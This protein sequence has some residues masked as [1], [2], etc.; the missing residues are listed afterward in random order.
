LN[1]QQCYIA[2]NLISF[3]QDRLLPSSDV[4][5]E[6]NLRKLHFGVAAAAAAGHGTPDPHGTAAGMTATV[7]GSE[8]GTATGTGLG[9]DKGAAGGR[10]QPSCPAGQP[11]NTYLSYKRKLQALM[12]RDVTLAE[13][14]R[15]NLY[16]MRKEVELFKTSR[17]HSRPSALRDSI[18]ELRVLSPYSASGI[19]LI[20]ET[21]A[22]LRW[23]KWPEN[24]C[25]P[26]WRRSAL[27]FIFKAL[28]L[29][30]LVPL[31]FAPD[32]DVNGGSVS[33]DVCVQDC[34]VDVALILQDFVQEFVSQSE[35]V[36]GLSIVTSAINVGLGLGLGR[37]QKEAEERHQQRI[38]L[39]CALRSVGEG[40]RCCDEI[41]SILQAEQVKTAF[42]APDGKVASDASPASASAAALQTELTMLQNHKEANGGTRKLLQGLLLSM[43]GLASDML[44]IP[45]SPFAENSRFG[46][47]LGLGIGS[48]GV[49]V[50]SGG[51]LPMDTEKW[52]S[53]VKEEQDAQKVIALLDEHMEAAASQFETQVE[54]DKRAKLKLR[55]RAASKV[56]KA[57]KRTSSTGTRA[58]SAVHHHGSSD[59]VTGNIN[60]GAGAPNQGLPYSGS[61]FTGGGGVHVYHRHHQEPESLLSL[62]HRHYHTHTSNHSQGTGTL[63]LP[64]QRH[65]AFER[66]TPGTT[67]ACLSDAGMQRAALFSEFVVQ[68]WEKRVVGEETAEWSCA[69]YRAKVLGRWSKKHLQTS[70]AA[71]LHESC[72]VIGLPTPGSND[73][74][75]HVIVAK[76]ETEGGSAPRQLLVDDMVTVDD[77]DAECPLA[78]MEVDALGAG[79]EE[80]E[81]EGGGALSYFGHLSAVF[82]TSRSSSSLALAQNPSGANLVDLRERGSTRDSISHSSHHKA[83]SLPDEL[84][85]ELGE[86]L[87]K[88]TNADALERDDATALGIVGDAN[89][90]GKGGGKDADLDLS[91]SDTFDVELG[92]GGGNT[93]RHSRDGHHVDLDEADPM[94]GG[95]AGDDSSGGNR[96]NSVARDSE[97]DG[98][99]G[100][101]RNEPQLSHTSMS[102]EVHDFDDGDLPHGGERGTPEDHGSQYSFEL[103]RYSTI[104]SM[105][106]GGNGGDGGDTNVGNNMAKDF[107]ETIYGCLGLAQALGPSAGPLPSSLESVHF[108]HLNP[109][110][111]VLPAFEKPAFEC[112]VKKITATG[113]SLGR[114]WVVKGERALYFEPSSAGTDDTVVTSEWLPR[115]RWSALTFES[116]LLRRYRLRDTGIE[117]FAQGGGS[118]FFAVVNKDGSSHTLHHHNSSVR[119]EFAKV[120]MTLMP[121]GAA[122][123][124][125]GSNGGASS[126]AAMRD[127]LTQQ[128][129]KYEISNFDYLMGLN[130]LAGRSFNNLSQYP[131]FPWVLCDFESDS[132]DLNDPVV[133]RDLSKPVGALNP[134]RLQEYV[135]R[136]DSLDPEGGTP[137][138]HYGSHYSTAGAVVL[139]FLLRMQPFAGLHREM[140]GGRFDLPDRLFKSLPDTWAISNTNLAEVKELIPELY[141]LPECLRNANRFDLGTTQDG[142]V[143]NDVE[144]P[145]WAHGS[146]DSFIKQHRAALESEHVSAHLH[147]WIDLIFGFKQRGK[148]A[149]EAHNVF[150][151]L[152]YYGAVDLDQI[153]DVSLQTALEDQIAHFGQCPAQLFSGPH[154]M[155]NKNSIPPAPTGLEWLQLVWKET[156]RGG[157]HVR[158]IDIPWSILTV[159]RR[160]KYDNEHHEAGA[161]LDTGA[162]PNAAA[163]TVLPLSSGD[164]AVT[165][166]ADGGGGSGDDDSD[167]GTTVQGALGNASGD[168]TCTTG[169][170]TGFGGLLEGSSSTFLS[171]GKVPVLERETGIP[172]QWAPAVVHASHRGAWPLHALKL[173]PGRVGYSIIGVDAR[174]MIEHYN[175][176]TTQKPEAVQ[177]PTGSGAG[178]G[179]GMPPP[180]MSGAPNADTDRASSAPELP[181]SD[182]H[183]TKT[184]K[185]GAASS[186][187]EQHGGQDARRVGVFHDDGDFT[188]SPPV[189][190]KEGLLADTAAGGTA[191]LTHQPRHEPDVQQHERDMSDLDDVDPSTIDITADLFDLL[192]NAISGVDACAPTPTPSAASTTPSPPGPCG[193]GAS[194]LQGLPSA[195]VMSPSSRSTSLQ[196]TTATTHGL[197]P[198]AVTAHE[199]LIRSASS[200][201]LWQQAQIAK[202]TNAAATGSSSAFSISGAFG[203]GSGGGHPGHSNGSG[204][205]FPEDVFPAAVASVGGGGGH[206]QPR[207]DAVVPSLRLSS[208]V[209]EQMWSPRDSRISKVECDFFEFETGGSRLA[210]GGDS[211]GGDSGGGS[212]SGDGEVVAFSD[213][214]SQ[215]AGGE[216][217]TTVA[218]EHPTPVVISTSGTLIFSGS[219]S[220]GEI[221]IRQ[222][223]DDTKQVI[224]VGTLFGHS[225]PVLCLS[226]SKDDRLLA[227][228]GLDTIV[229]VWQIS[230]ISQ[231]YRKPHLSRRPMHM[232]RGHVSGVVDLCLESVLGVCISVS[233]MGDA[234]L[235]TLHNGALVRRLVP[236]NRTPEKPRRY[237]SESDLWDTFGLGAGRIR[238]RHHHAGPTPYRCHHTHSFHKVA[239]VSQPLAYV[240]F[241]TRVTDKNAITTGSDVLEMW[242]LNGAFV[243]SRHLHGRQGFYFLFSPFFLFLSLTCSCFVLALFPLCLSPFL[244]FCFV[245]TLVLFDILFLPLLSP[246]SSKSAK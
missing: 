26:V 189:Q 73:G 187:Q 87:R 1:E 192:S 108:Q 123:Q 234:L 222:V 206:T 172:P 186:L 138:F 7:A 117:F 49:V 90:D 5:L 200:D 9:G 148:A 28:P 179:T 124:W 77:A 174:G 79:H 30:T 220:S 158:G 142:D 51:V 161:L 235:H 80:G 150:Y 114:I 218:R 103:S 173:L 229:L 244:I 149:K 232:L 182:L 168:G 225:A 84:Q 38:L 75:H 83:A 196:T 246:F 164:A 48:K 53:I 130:M 209:E 55:A 122:K 33:V 96:K 140:Q 78:F 166:I 175:T 147:E 59:D 104:H 228:G 63:P 91:Q 57:N 13:K 163:A 109:A 139:H 3:I 32:D 159:L 95:N 12:Q 27:N 126:L 72:V 2:Y 242:S 100:S 134:E 243:A 146:A 233:T 47:A 29:L 19:H 154:P 131:V 105:I 215:T 52:L 177:D 102:S 221:D 129:H 133:F 178:A 85:F 37:R 236:C 14:E 204:S 21:L 35:D 171:P 70:C 197:L 208:I 135:E 106:G 15:L 224:G 25:P 227:S 198:T 42:H 132:L 92:L 152:T 167:P 23:S 4:A 69:L 183:K 8:T 94:G 216:A 156:R 118:V 194:L 82:S 34:I 41:E 219:P 245:F 62:D 86:R 217:T 241:A 58:D 71:Y 89:G 185:G 40:I 74:T 112:S 56:S 127:K 115:E 144:L 46:I 195:S 226:F 145:P 66:W 128:W 201:T 143:V 176:S 181:L 65:A 170:G 153:E 184:T 193:V 125:P 190:N 20:K 18:N 36:S 24:V 223:A 165:S 113:F 107:S 43:A 54:G 239:C 212:G 116:A 213:P 121:S 111:P 119:N 151:Y 120:V 99:S 16:L 10:Q 162:L 231:S 39:L 6:I 136:Y 11:N 191:S 50:G 81:G 61:S 169:H 101:I 137:R 141:C 93:L 160:M 64:S 155:R 22:L 238:S 44:C 98:G 188:A 31:F 17:R 230:K 240:L 45:S 76:L 202:Q 205:T 97:D 210:L 214:S 157:T 88:F 68:Q 60:G 199:A 237:L 211:G 110:E 203:G 207:V 180:Y 67:N